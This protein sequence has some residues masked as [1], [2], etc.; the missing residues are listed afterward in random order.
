MWLVLPASWWWERVGGLQG[1]MVFS[2]ER[3]FPLRG[4]DLG[5][6]PLTPSLRLHDAQVPSGFHLLGWSRLAQSSRPP[7]NHCQ[8]KDPG[9]GSRSGHPAAPPGWGEA[10]GLPGVPVGLSHPAARPR[11]SHS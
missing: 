5:E 8:G 11:T 1:R 4:V 10:L 2:L 6:R 7:L 3:C 9:L